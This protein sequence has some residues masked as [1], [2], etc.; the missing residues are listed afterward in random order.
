MCRMN[1]AYA[2]RYTHSV[3]LYINFKPDYVKGSIFTMI[4][5]AIDFIIG[6]VYKRGTEVDIMGFEDFKW[7]EF[8]LMYVRIRSQKRQMLFSPY[9]ENENSHSDTP[10]L[11]SPCFFYLLYTTIKALVVVMFSNPMYNLR[12]TWHV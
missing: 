9:G 2:K 8:I 7:N 3:W 5:W 1:T 10:R 6:L 12:F 11:F 4:F